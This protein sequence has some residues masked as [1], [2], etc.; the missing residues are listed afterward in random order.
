MI[1][2]KKQSTYLVAEIGWNFLGNI[3]L[4]KKMILGAKIS[5]A[6]AV[7]F[8]IWDPSKLKNGPWDKD[9]R[10]KIYEKSALTFKTYKLLKKFSQKNNIFCF[11]SVFTAD[12][13]KIIK[14]SGDKVV[15]IPSHES[16]NIP[17][18][19]MAL[20]NFQQVV[21]SVGALTLPELKKIFFLKNK[22]KVIILHCVSSYPLKI[23][24]CNFFK[25]NFLKKKFKN[26]G[27]S[28]HLKGNE[29]SIY[30]MANGAVLV[31]KHFTINK[32]LSG[33][34]NKFSLSPN[35]FSEL[36]KWREN[37]KL[38]NKKKTIS[39]LNCEREIVRKC[40]GRWQKN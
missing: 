15:K 2:I 30:A 1:K 32:N 18:I 28:G 38:F 34:D 27:Y 5:G 10:R 11:A 13:L 14:R 33:R 3:N 39:L 37:I 35:E 26:V 7:K 12:S 20:K 36:Q 40:R 23:E 6:D 17:L 16:Y 19:K 31:E 29:D 8:Q 21:I 25:F 24:N 4:A 9:G 22:N